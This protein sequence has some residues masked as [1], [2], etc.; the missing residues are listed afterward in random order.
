[1]QDVMKQETIIE[2][3]LMWRAFPLGNAFL[4]DRNTNNHNENLFSK[5]WVILCFIRQED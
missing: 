3:V 2:K 4:S 5:Y 1:M